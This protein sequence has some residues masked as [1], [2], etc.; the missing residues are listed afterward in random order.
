MNRGKIIG[1]QASRA[2]NDR[3]RSV[4]EVRYFHDDGRQET[5]RFDSPFTIGRDSSC[6]IRLDSKLVSRRHAKIYNDGSHWYVHD[7][8]SSNGT[9]ISGRRISDHELVGRCQI[10]LGMEGPILSFEPIQMS[11]Q[12][13]LDEPGY[14][15]QGEP[16]SVT[17][18]VRRY[19]D[20]G[21]E[22]NAD[23]QAK[24]VREAFNRVSR[25][26]TLKYRGIVG[27]FV[28]LLV[29]AF[30]IGVYQYQK[31][32][33]MNAMAVDIFYAMKTLE[34][35]LAQ[36][37]QKAEESGSSN[38]KTQVL[39]KR[40][41][42]NNSK[43]AYDRYLI[44]SGLFDSSLDDT[45]RLILKVARIFGESELEMPDNFTEEV[46]RYIGMWQST[47]RLKTAIDRAEVYDFIPTTLAAMERYNLP[48]QFFYLGLQESG[49]RIDATG[50]QTRH[51]I[52]KGPWQFIPKTAKR[53]GLKTGPLA[54]KRQ[55]DPLD[56]RFD[57]RRS[58][59][60][61]A[62]YLK[63]IYATEAQA[64]GLLVMASYNWGEHNIRRLVNKLPENPRDRNFWQLIKQHNIPEETYDYVLYIFSAAVIGE[65]P[66][67]FG[68]DFDNPLSVPDV[69]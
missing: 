22:Q 68:F 6:E 23:D 28:V 37:E 67:L 66:R 8:E 45:E 49:F 39:Q 50:P 13:P 46:K 59:Y 17:Q 30:G 44:D 9:F 12:R 21:M 19:L 33:K 10:R 18:F 65:N 26:R 62:H 16:G 48:Q 57:V 4:M 40:Q 15:T 60:A 38:D 29:A 7:L 5:L 54:E 51:G 35:Q 31:I 27:V 34:I 1:S 61:A 43:V 55:F 42:F 56:D 36:L 14:V 69:T 63:D 24:I 20:R 47:Q 41:Q 3:Y 52:A 58:T 25:Q 32:K 53:Y 2:E 64:S 11:I